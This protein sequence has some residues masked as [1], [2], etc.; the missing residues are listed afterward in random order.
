M[1]FFYFYSSVLQL[2]GTLQL[3]VKTKNIKK[4][5]GLKLK[6]ATTLRRLFISP[7]IMPISTGPVKPKHH[8]DGSALTGRGLALRG[9]L[10]H[11]A[12]ALRYRRPLLLMLLFLQRLPGSTIRRYGIAALRGGAFLG[13]WGWVTSDRPRLR[14]LELLLLVVAR[15]EG[16]LVPFLLLGLGRESSCC[17]ACALAAVGRLSTSWCRCLRGRGWGLLRPRL[18]AAEGLGA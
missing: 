2:S 15:V 13:T 8:R 3:R 10:E 18:H 7:S 4:S 9:Y 6:R 11:A 5:L 1:F 12:P 16:R 17:P 14:L